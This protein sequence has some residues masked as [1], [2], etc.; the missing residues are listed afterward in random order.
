MSSL[1][2]RIKSFKGYP[3]RYETIT[4]YLPINPR[5]GKCGACG[6]FVGDGKITTTQMHHWIYE[7]KPATVKENPELALRNTE[8]YC[9]Y[10][11]GIADG[12]RA[13]LTANPDRVVDVMK[14]MPLKS[15]ERLLLILADII[16]YWNNQAQ[17]RDEQIKSIKE[18][19]GI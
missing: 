6:Q 15:R 2:Q 8:E 9:F 5:K 1:P 19:L 4:V 16:T 3:L 11:H 10:D 14:T 7:F 18:N 12:F 13:I 17:G